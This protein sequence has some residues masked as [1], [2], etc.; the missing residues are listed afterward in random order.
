MPFDTPSGAPI[1]VSHQ[2]Q[3]VLYLSMV[4]CNSISFYSVQAR[5]SMS[6][7]KSMMLLNANQPNEEEFSGRKAISNSVRQ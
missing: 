2:Q 5:C 3:Q 1:F 7:L 4:T 6:L